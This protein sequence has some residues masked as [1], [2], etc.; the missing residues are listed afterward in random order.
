ML[1]RHSEHMEDALAGLSPEDRALLELS[2]MRGVSDEEI[3]G[4][5]RVDTHHVRVRRDE[6]LDQLIERL[7]DA[8]DLGELFGHENGHASPPAKDGAVLPAVS[9]GEAPPARSNDA[10]TSATA[11][12]ARPRRLTLLGLGLVAVVVL[13]IVVASTR[14]GGG[15]Q[16]QLGERQPSPPER[17]PPAAKPAPKEKALAKPKPAG[18]RAS[19]QA[20]AAAPGA[21]ANA[22]IAKDRLQLR[23]AGLPEGSYTVWLYDSVADAKPLVRFDGSPTDLSTALPKGY[24]RYGSLDISREPADRNPN[25]SGESL[26]RVPLPKLTR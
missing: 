24:E 5:L 16:A 13:A 23:V 26:L 7:D 12:S 4:L 8:A 9:E 18:P 10:A 1:T 6:A 11:S 21:S 15:E 22:K 3:A 2:L 20:L 17:K 14:G 25:H 19:L